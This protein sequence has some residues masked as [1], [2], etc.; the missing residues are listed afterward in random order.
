MSYPEGSYTIERRDQ[1]QQKSL[2]EPIP[3]SPEFLN[4]LWHRRAAKQAAQDLANNAEEAGIAY[5]VVEAAGRVL[6][7]YVSRASERKREEPRSERVGATKK[8]PAYRGALV[9]AD[10]VGI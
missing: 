2:W 7:T 1:A 5:R 3:S 8:R 6:V 4:P 10:L 9:H